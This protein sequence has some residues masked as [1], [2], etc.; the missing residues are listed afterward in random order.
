MP[1]NQ[2]IRLYSFHRQVNPSDCVDMDC[3]AMKKLM[4]HDTDG[5]TMDIGGPGTII[6]DSAFEWNGDPRRGLG[7]YRIPKTMLTRLD[8]SRIPIEDVAPNQ[9]GL[10][11]N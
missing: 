4:F 7:D 3:D 9:G 2:I 11:I 1:D 8:G 10:I 6:P 5:S